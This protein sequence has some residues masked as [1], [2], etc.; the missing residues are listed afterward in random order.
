MAAASLF[1]GMGL[2]ERSLGAVHGF[3]G[4]MAVCPCAAW[5]NLALPYCLM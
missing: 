1:G 2:G 4:P 3:A 5:R